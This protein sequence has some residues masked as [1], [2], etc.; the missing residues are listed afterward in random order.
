M[1]DAIRAEVPANFTP[2]EASAPAASQEASGARF[3]AVR[4]AER[5]AP[6]AVPPVSELAA[7]DRSAPPPPEQERGRSVS[8]RA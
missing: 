5:N 7:A 4:D 3:E 8:V 1:V 2:R 6:G